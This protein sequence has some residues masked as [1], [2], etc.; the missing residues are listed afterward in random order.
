[1]ITSINHITLTVSCLHTSLAFY[2]DLLG[3]KPRVKWKNGAYLTSGDVWLCLTL[4]KPEPA[5]D[6]SHIALIVNEEKLH[7]FNVDLCESSVR[8][9]QENSSE[10]CSIYLLD[11]DDHKLELHVGDI[12]TRLLALKNEPYENLEWL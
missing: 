11:P 2:S 5:N 6:Y 4:G 9:W 12:N 10:G 8:Q 3:F 7:K 1:M